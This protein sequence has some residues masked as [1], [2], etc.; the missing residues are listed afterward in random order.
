M[1]LLALSHAAVGDDHATK[2]TLGQ[3][4]TDAVMTV[5]NIDLGNDVTTISGKGK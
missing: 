4:Q 5:T 1:M 2:L 3:R